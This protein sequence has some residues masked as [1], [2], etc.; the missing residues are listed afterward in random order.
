MVF[1]IIYKAPVTLTSFFLKTTVILPAKML[2]KVLGASARWGRNGANRTR[3]Y[4][5]NSTS[6]SSRATYTN[7]ATY[8]YSGFGIRSKVYNSTNFMY[9]NTNA[10]VKRGF[11]TTGRFSHRLYSTATGAKAAGKCNVYM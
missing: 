11:S 4:Y 7:A 8:S 3:T 5:T 6:R 2:G 10:L 9:T 1:S